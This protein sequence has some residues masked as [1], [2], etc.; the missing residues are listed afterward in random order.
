MTAPGNDEFYV[1]GGTLRPDAPCYV[2]RQADRDLCVSLLAGEFCYVLTARQVGKSSLMVRTAQRLRAEGVRIVVLDLT[3]VGQ[4]LSPEQWYDGLLAHAGRQLRMERELEDF[5]AKHTHLGPC[6]RLF[7][8][9]R[10]ITLAEPHA[11]LASRSVADG[12]ALVIFVDEIDAVRSLPFSTDEFFAA[13]RECYNRRAE[14]RVLKRMTFC[15]LGVATPSDLIRDTRTTPFNIGRRVEL[16]DFTAAEASSLLPGLRVAPAESPEA[17]DRVASFML[18]RILYWTHGHPYLTQRLCRDVVETLALAV[19]KEARGVVGGPTARSTQ[20]LDPAAVAQRVDEVCQT[21]FLT[22]Q[23]RE[24]DDNLL[25][26]RE[27]LL[28]SE[29]DHSTLLALYGRVLRVTS[30]ALNRLEHR[31]LAVARGSSWGTDVPDDPANP[32]VSVLRLSGLVRVQAGFLRVRNEIYARVFDADWVRSQLPDAEVRRQREALWLGAARTAGIAAVMLAVVGFLAVFAWKESRRARQLA[33]QNA[34]RLVRLSVSYGD[35]LMEGGDLLSAFQRFVEA[36]KH[37][38]NASHQDLH[39]R[40]IATV[41]QQCP[42]LVQAWWLDADV[43]D[44]AFSPDGRWVGSARADGAVEIWDTVEG[45]PVGPPIHHAPSAVAVSFHPDGSRLVT[46]GRDGTARVWKVVTGQP[47]LPPLVQSATAFESGIGIGA[48]FSPDGSTLV[49]YGG[50]DSAARL[51]DAA[52]GQCRSVL[53]HQDMVLYAAFS[54]DGRQVVTASADHT[55]Q[56]WEVASG[57]RVGAALQHQGDVVRANFSPDGTRVVTASRDA[58]GRLWEAATGQPVNLPLEHLTW[59]TDATY[60]P[61]GRYVVTSSFDGF[62]RVWDAA[63][64]KPFSSPLRH[65][66]SVMAASFSP[67]G[68]LVLTACFNQTA[69]VW[70]LG[71]GA[72]VL[73][74]LKHSGYV[75]QAVFS[76]DGRRVLTRGADRAVRLWDLATDEGNLPPLE[77]RTKVN[78]IAISPDGGSLLTGAEDGQARLWSMRTGQLLRPPMDHP[79]PVLQ[80]AYRADGRAFLTAGA[81]GRVRL[82][83]ARTAEL[84]VP[85]LGQEAPVDRAQFSADGRRVFAASTTSG[86]AAFWDATT[87]QRVGAEIRFGRAVV[88]VA[89]SPDGGKAACAGPG[90][91]VD[92]WSTTG[93]RPAP[94]KLPHEHDVQHVAFSPDGRRLITSCCDATFAELYA[95]V[96]DADTGQRLSPRLQH[97]DGVATSQFSP[98]GRWVLTASEDG[99]AGIWD[100]AS[101]K[102]S[103]PFLRH[104]YQVQSAA[105]STDSR[106]VVTASRDHTARVWDAESGDP[107]TPPLRHGERVHHA[108]FSPD[109]THVVTASRDGRVRI[110]DLRPDPSPVADLEVLAQLLN[111]RQIDPSGGLVPTETA[112]LRETWRA[113]LHTHPEAFRTSPWAIVAWHRTQLEACLT[114]KR[115]FAALHHADCLHVLAPNDP[116]LAAL[117]SKAQRELASERLGP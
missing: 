70:D 38:G 100:A 95:Q 84:L 97:N 1:T 88:H 8:S 52:S 36:L 94:L 33:G 101:G 98:D 3:A 111:S 106:L 93:D 18:A 2:E 46:A 85:P 23:A 82:F 21:L 113:L 10:N 89:F 7:A 116:D 61:D 29:V 6:Q 105:F 24:Q 14:D 5:W 74:P 13:I 26:V 22:P 86:W 45:K 87:G 4:N 40:R 90:H 27:R 30:L 57:A 20:P 39:R 51:W 78:A 75:P 12:P 55:G 102:L 92:V 11:S 48:A 58:T 15:L 72:R 65:G 64:G 73:A 56:V 42:R 77:H 103:V 76:P 9:L 109:G 17:G 108:A 104:D 115:W 37:E 60:S 59:L 66:H 34:E 117:R 68:T 53:S 16:H 80:V 19:A 81:D 28:R 67:D 63:T 43:N 50:R 114:S 31:F 91:E 69:Q 107:I 47:V 99:S 83:D 62:A 71:T 25:F 35:R 41:L 32:I 112:R 110:W 49:T 54:R 79:A 44:V 96:W